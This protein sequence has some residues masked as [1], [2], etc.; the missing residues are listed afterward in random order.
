MLLI[1]KYDVCKKDINVK[2][3]TRRRKKMKKRFISV[4][5][6]IMVVVMCVACGAKTCHFCGNQIET[7]PL[8]K[9]DR[10]YCDYDCYMR[11]VMGL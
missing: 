4:L 9:D 10:V 5:I 8:K 7:E 2:S 3:V 6:M 1:R 11:E